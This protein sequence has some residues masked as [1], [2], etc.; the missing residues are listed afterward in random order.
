MTRCLRAIGQL[1]QLDHVLRNVGYRNGVYF[2]LPDAL[3]ALQQLGSSFW[4]HDSGRACESESGL[5]AKYAFERLRGFDGPDALAVCHIRQ[6]AGLAARSSPE[7]S[8]I[9][10]V[11]SGK[12]KVKDFSD[13]IGKQDWRLAGSP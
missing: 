4:T 8:R 5:L 2:L 12:S 7:N 10:F 13:P 9:C 6:N 3:P 1:S 11:L